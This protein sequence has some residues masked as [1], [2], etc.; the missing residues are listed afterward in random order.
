M[1]LLTPGGSS[2]NP[3]VFPLFTMARPRRRELPLC[4]EVLRLHDAGKRLFGE[5]FLGNAISRI[6]SHFFWP[7]DTRFS[8]ATERLFFAFCSLVPPWASPSR[9]ATPAFFVPPGLETIGR[10]TRAG[11]SNDAEACTHF[12]AKGGVDSYGFAACVH[13]DQ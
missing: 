1:L 6:L 5:V 4:R 2:D 8:S 11:N 13:K 9:L 12:V 7:L 3:T 10:K